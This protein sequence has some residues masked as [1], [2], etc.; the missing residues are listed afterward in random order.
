MRCKFCGDET[1][2]VLNCCAEC[3]PQPA[4]KEELDFLVENPQEWYRQRMANQPPRHT[5]LVTFTKAADVDIDK[6]KQRLKFEMS[7]KFVTS[8]SLVIEHEDGNIHAH[9][10]IKSTK[11]IKKSREYRSYIKAYGFVDVK[12]VKFDNGVDEYLAKEC[13]P[14]IKVED[15]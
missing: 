7:R 8:F 9:A 1:H 4:D 11:Y 6:W 13:T 15:I 2:S 10:K 12:N 5:Y 14:V 3:L